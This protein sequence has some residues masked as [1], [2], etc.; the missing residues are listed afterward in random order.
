MADREEKLCQPF[1]SK[2]IKGNSAPGRRQEG[3]NCPLK[4]P[5]QGMYSLL[6]ALAVSPG[7]GLGTG[8]PHREASGLQNWL[9]NKSYAQ[10]GLWLVNIDQL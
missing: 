2:G 4:L 7:P 6:L 5:G 9:V 1:Y 10:L 8:G 3:G